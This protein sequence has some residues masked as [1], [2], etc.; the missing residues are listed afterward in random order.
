MD[1]RDYI[2]SSRTPFNINDTI[3]K[4]DNMSF[5]LRKGTLNL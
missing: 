5:G 4:G 3:H 2:Q 1:R